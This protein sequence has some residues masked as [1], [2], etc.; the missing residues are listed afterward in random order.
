MPVE[1]KTG[2]WAETALLETERSC[3]AVMRSE[4]EGKCSELPRLLAIA[5]VVRCLWVA[6]VLVLVY[7]EK[8]ICWLVLAVNE[9]N[10]RWSNMEER[11]VFG[12]V[13]W[14][15]GPVGEETYERVVVA[16]VG[17]IPRQRIGRSSWV[18]AF[19]A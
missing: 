17:C 19:L 7:E 4:A 5:T 9:R 16:F 6:G 8:H 15:K 18:W 2:T 1:Q 10:R 11:R 14:M 3:P 12:L 13:G